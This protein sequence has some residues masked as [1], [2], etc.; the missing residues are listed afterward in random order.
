MLGLHYGDIGAMLMENW[1][2]PE[3]LQILTRNQPIPAEASELKTESTLLHLAHEWALIETKDSPETDDICIDA[4][5]QAV[6]GLSQ[7]Q[8]EKTLD[9]ARSISADMEKVILA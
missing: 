1:N 4:E 3:T 8:L 2:L 5:I 6:T 7:D 9:E